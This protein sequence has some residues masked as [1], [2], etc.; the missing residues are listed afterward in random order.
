MTLKEK[1]QPK[2]LQVLQEAS[3]DYPNAIKSV[4]E[5]L[6]NESYLIDL[7]FGTVYAILTF[8]EKDYSNEEMQS[9]VTNPYNLFL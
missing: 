8:I 2:V 6:E 9:M 4:F 5:E 7:R 1:L 3:V